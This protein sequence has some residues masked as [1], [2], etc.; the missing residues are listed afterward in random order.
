MKRI[1]LAITLVFSLFVSLMIGFQFVNLATANPIGEQSWASSPIISI[2]LPSD[3]EIVSSSE[4]PLNFTITKPEHSWLIKGG[5]EEKRNILLSVRIILDDTLY[6]S[7]EVNSTLS[8]PFSHYDTL[9]KLTDGEHNLFIQTVCEGWNIE[10]HG[11]WANKF[12]YENSSNSIAFTVNKSAPS[13]E[14]QQ[15]TPSI[16]AQQTNSFPTTIVLAS[17][18]IVVIV[19]T[20][21]LVYFKR[22]NMF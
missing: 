20:S 8:E 6:R 5:S 13:K 17:V 7:I 12:I 16:E 1:A 2:N 4:A 22:C 15:T 10:F 19:C 14:P 9:T 3:N 11:L 18:S 21:L